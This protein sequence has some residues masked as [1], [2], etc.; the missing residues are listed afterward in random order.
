MNS[1]AMRTDSSHQSNDAAR[2]TRDPDDTAHGGSDQRG[3]RTAHGPS[4]LTDAQRIHEL[5]SLLD[6]S[7]RCLRLVRAAL[8]GMHRDARTGDPADSAAQSDD[9]GGA[10]TSNES[11]ALHRLSTAEHAMQRMVELLGLPTSNSNRF[12]AECPADQS[13][14][15]DTAAEARTLSVVVD[16]VMTLLAPLAHESAVALSADV[17]GCCAAI[18]AGPLDIVLHNV[19]R[20]AI[21][22]CGHVDVASRCVELTV[23]RTLER[24]VSITVAD[25][26][27]GFPMDVM[28]ERTS[29]A[30]NRANGRGHGLTICR[31]I[32]GDLNGTMQ[33]TNIPFHRG[34]VVHITIPMPEFD[35]T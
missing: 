13:T 32:I 14:T 33:I 16:R 1:T 28:V 29:Q 30:T 18:H 9:D 22:A 6:G 4:G 3:D 11:S 17:A 20:N 15:S 23:R 12:A 35:A 27:P 10:S 5:R 21:E 7:M 8:D 34:A 26:G 24:A 2:S 31:Q 19:M 25:T